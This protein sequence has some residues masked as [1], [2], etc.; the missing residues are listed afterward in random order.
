MRFLIYS[1]FFFSVALILTSCSGKQYQALFEKK[2]KMADSL[3][4]KAAAPVVDYRIQPQDIL[5]IRNLQRL[6]YIVDV[7][8]NSG[9]PV[10]GGTSQ[11]A[12]FQVEEDGNVALPVIGRVQVADLTRVEATKKIEDLY[13]A[14]LLKDPIIELK[15]INLKVTILGEIRSQGNYPLI[16]DR[17]TLVEMIG[18]AGGLSDRA[19]ETD[20]RIIR[21]TKNDPE[22]KRFDLSNISSIT[23]PAAILHNGDIIFIAENKRAVRVDK[24]STF[25]VILQP[26]LIIINTALI[27]FTLAHR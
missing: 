27:I 2:E 10:G 26:A 15:I 22:V 25:S 23:D 6:S 17:T 9:S 16:K 4:Q 18:E 5:Q 12:T 8:A 11:D 1:Y 20:V 19:D 7:P 3:S 14:V 13:R 21:G 24:L